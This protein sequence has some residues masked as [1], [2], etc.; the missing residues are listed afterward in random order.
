MQVRA[1]G[2]DALLCFMSI[3]RKCPVNLH[4]PSSISRTIQSRDAYRRR[5][6]KGTRVGQG[7]RKFD[8]GFILDWRFRENKHP[9]Y[10]TKLL[11]PVQNAKYNHIKAAGIEKLLIYAAFF[12]CRRILDLPWCRLGSLPASQLMLPLVH[13]DVSAITPSRNVFPYCLGVFLYS[14]DSLIN[15]V[16]CSAKIKSCVPGN[17]ST[18]DL[19]EDVSIAWK[20]VHSSQRRKRNRCCR[21]CVRLNYK[22]IQCLADGYFHAPVRSVDRILQ[23][24]APAIYYCLLTK[25]MT[26]AIHG[27]TG[28]LSHLPTTTEDKTKAPAT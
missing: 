19:V 9:R 14:C 18:V 2:D 8:G 4:R 3:T 22:T 13:S 17:R 21:D 15:L 1:I 25:L 23:A 7:G 5:E 24:G 26:S 6:R 28:S 16:L 12:R 27:S 11:A 10:K 20:Q